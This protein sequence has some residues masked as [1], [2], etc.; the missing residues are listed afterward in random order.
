MQKVVVCSV[1]VV[2]VI[3]FLAILLPFY[4]RVRSN[5]LPKLLCKGSA[6]C[7][8]GVVED[9]VDGDTLEVNGEMVRLALINTP[10]K[11]E[12][13]YDAA[14]DFVW[15]VCPIGNEVVVDEDDLQISGSHRRMVGVV[16]CESR[17]RFRNLNEELLKAEYARILADFCERSEFANE[18]WAKLYGCSELS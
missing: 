5:T 1:V 3:G 12:Y 8:E 17:G 18:E 10:E 2:V 4:I 16:Y 9:V 11:W 7:F 14:I 6:R 13:D 15:T